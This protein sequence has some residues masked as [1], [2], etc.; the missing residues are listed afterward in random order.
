MHMYFHVSSLV[1]T[2]LLLSSPQVS[3]TPNSDWG[4]EGSLGCGIGFG[5]LHRLPAHKAAAGDRGHTDVEAGGAPGNIAP[6]S[7]P[8]AEGY[9][10]VSKMLLCHFGGLCA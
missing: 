6:A 7:S 4:G 10:D 1:P 8:P 9:S 5:Y 3:L 2:P